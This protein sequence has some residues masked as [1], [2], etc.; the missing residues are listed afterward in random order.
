MAGVLDAVPDRRLYRPVVGRGRHDAHT[1]GV[2]D[3]AFGH[4][5]DLHRRSPFEI[6][7]MGK[8]ITNVRPQ[9][10]ED[11]VDDLIG[12]RRPDQHERRR[13]EGGD[14][15]CKW[16]NR[17]AV[18]WLAPTP[19]AV[20]RRST[21]RPQSKRKLWPPA[22]TSVDGPARSGSGI[23]LPVPRTMTSSALI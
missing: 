1:V 15:L 12:V 19:T 3:H 22:W 5:G 14:P 13:R 23:G 11:A 8:A 20:L 17:V 6:G 2:E 9:R 7:V 4:F 10:R 21:P 18:N 16:V